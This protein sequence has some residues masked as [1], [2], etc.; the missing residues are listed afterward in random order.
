MGRCG[1]HS[2]PSR[3]PLLLLLLLL[4]VPGVGAAQLSVLYTS[5]D[6]LTLLQADTVRGAVLGSRSAWA[7]EFFASWCGHCIAFAPT[8]KALANDVKGEESRPPLGYPGR[9]RHLPREGPLAPGQLPAFG[10]LCPALPV[11]RSP[12]S[13]PSSPFLPFP[14]WSPHL[15]AACAPDLCSSLLPLPGGCPHPYE[16]SLVP[17]A[18]ATL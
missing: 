15:F 12:L 17:R 18:L 13:Y 2:G 6:P 1:R 7:V 14:L 10:P 9:P 16:G 4:A 3:S 8:W 5:S 11:C